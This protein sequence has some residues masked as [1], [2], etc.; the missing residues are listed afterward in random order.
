MVA[1]L[2][3][4][5]AACSSSGVTTPVS[6]ASDLVVTSDIAMA[7]ADGAAEDVDVMTGM[8]GAPGNISADVGGGIANSLGSWRPGLT[9]CTFASGSFTCPDTL[10]NGLHVTRVVTLLNAAGGTMSAYDSLLTASIHI[11]ADISGD[12]THGPW[13]ATVAR[14]HD[15]TVTGLAGTETSRT[16]NGSGNETVSQSRVLRNDST[17]SY[18]ITGTSTITNVV[19]PVRST[20]GGNGWPTSGTITRTMTVTLTSGPNAGKTETKTMTITFDGTSTPSGSIDGHTFTI[21]C[22]NHTATPRS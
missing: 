12:R 4:V 22:T 3:V 9:G 7:A 1:G 16:F 2:F 5:A 8:N 15:I 11:V 18:T 14:H 10:R 20:D 13:S 19:M 17:R 21:D 6:T